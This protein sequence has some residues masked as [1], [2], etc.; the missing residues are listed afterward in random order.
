ML[1]VYSVG[2]RHEAKKLLVLACPTNYK[3]EF[4]APELGLEQTI[5]NL[6]K[7]SDKLDR[8]H[9]LL[10]S[11]GGCEC[12]RKSSGRGRLTSPEGG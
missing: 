8:F 1:P 2:S 5:E 3:H 6:E 4:I 10:A 11:H 7:L 12:R 9:D